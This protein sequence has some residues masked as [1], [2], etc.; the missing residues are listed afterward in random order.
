MLQPHSVLFNIYCNKWAES[1][2]CTDVKKRIGCLS[3]DNM[4]LPNYIIPQQ[5]LGKFRCPEENYR[6]LIY[7]SPFNKDQI[8]VNNL[9]IFTHKRV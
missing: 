6:P 7:S 9:F 8:P 4:S 2:G 5:N 3:L 1:N